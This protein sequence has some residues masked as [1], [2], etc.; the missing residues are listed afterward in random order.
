MGLQAV[1][2]APDAFM[3]VSAPLHLDIIVGSLRGIRWR[4]TDGDGEK[5]QDSEK[6]WVIKTENDRD[7][8]KIM[9]L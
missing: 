8:E 2:K 5:Y 3:C 4:E 7:K 1:L 6:R 9:I